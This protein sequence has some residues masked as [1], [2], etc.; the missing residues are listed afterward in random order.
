MVNYHFFDLCPVAMVWL[1]SYDLIL[2]IY[3]E[4]NNLGTSKCVTGKASE[5]IFDSH[6]GTDWE[7]FG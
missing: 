7:T 6:L 5:L 1:F 3:K 2:L 4:G